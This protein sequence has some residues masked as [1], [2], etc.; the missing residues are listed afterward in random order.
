M[1]LVRSFVKFSVMPPS[2]P[3]AVATA[4]AATVKPARMMAATVEP[5]VSDAE[6][7]AE[8]MSSRAVMASPDLLDHRG[9]LANPS[10]GQ[11]GRVECERARRCETNARQG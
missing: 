4:M 10:A 9:C 2:V 1:F 11:A 5:A 3:S 8:P 6:E 7:P